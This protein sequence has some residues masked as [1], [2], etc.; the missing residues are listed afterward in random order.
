MYVCGQNTV[1]TYHFVQS[2]APNTLVRDFAAI[3]LSSYDMDLKIY[4][5]TSLLEKLTI[6]PS[7]LGQIL[8]KI[9]IVPPIGY[10]LGAIR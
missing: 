5:T 6:N 9:K 10:S 1:T 4:K 2:W 7:Q 3:R 8:T